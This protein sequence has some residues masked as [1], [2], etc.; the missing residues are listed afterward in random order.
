MKK[1]YIAPKT[2]IVKVEQTLPLALSTTGATFIDGNAT[3]P[4]M[5]PTLEP[6]AFDAFNAFNEFNDALQDI[7]KT[8]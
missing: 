5:A 3:G 4:G 8:Y 7:M 1:K 2:E 6:D